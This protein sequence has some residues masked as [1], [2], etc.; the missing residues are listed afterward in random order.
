MRNDRRFAQVAS[1]ASIG[2][3]ILG[4]N[5]VSDANTSFGDNFTPTA[6][7]GGYS[8]GGFESFAGNSGNEALTQVGTSSV[9]TDAQG[10]LYQA[11][12]VPGT[13]TPA[14]EVT[15]P[16]GNSGY[17][18]AMLFDFAAAG[19]DSAFAANDIISFNV[20]YPAQS[21]STGYQQ[22]P[23]FTLNSSTGGFYQTGTSPNNAFQGYG[24]TTAQ[25]TD[26]F[27][28]NY[29]SQKSA[30]DSGTA[31]YLQMIFAL[32]NDGTHNVYYFSNF[33]LSPVPEPASFSVLCLSSMGI[34]MRRRHRSI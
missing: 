26:T 17:I 32:Q 19:L 20:T 15:T 8:M 23:Q 30:I 2:L 28:F 27:S 6:V 29:D 24:G 5:S 18:N 21:A 33:Q 3:A 25:I 34:F 9:Y 12:T 7:T 22:I 1:A 14:L 11:T 16:S 4:I 31:T 10:D 13:A